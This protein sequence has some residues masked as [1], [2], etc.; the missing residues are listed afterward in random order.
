MTDAAPTPRPPTM[1][2]NE[3]SQ[4]PNARPQPSALAMNRIAAMTITRMR[5]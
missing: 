3:K 1:R 5:P 2:Q 4:T